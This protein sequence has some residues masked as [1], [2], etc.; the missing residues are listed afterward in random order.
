MGD[1]INPDVTAPDVAEYP[2][3]CW[4]CEGV[5]CMIPEKD[6]GPIYQGGPPAFDGDDC[7]P[8]KTY[9]MIEKKHAKKAKKK[10]KK[11][12]KDRS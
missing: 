11:G 1:T 3:K 9:Q 5:W 4:K 8:D 2:Q 10:R 12:K 6:Q 7:S